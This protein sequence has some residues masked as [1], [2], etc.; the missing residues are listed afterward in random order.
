MLG[1][2]GVLSSFRGCRG[3]IFKDAGVEL[4]I[5]EG[6]LRVKSDIQI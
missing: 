3:C 5:V 2:A 1:Y 4:I 6:T